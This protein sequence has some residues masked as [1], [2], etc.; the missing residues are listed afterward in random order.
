MAAAL[1]RGQAL[2]LQKKDLTPGDAAE[3]APYLREKMTT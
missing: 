3:F 2:L 1:W